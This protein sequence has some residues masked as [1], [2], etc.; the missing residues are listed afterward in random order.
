MFYI[1]MK[2]KTIKDKKIKYAAPEKKKAVKKN[3]PVFLDKS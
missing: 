3:P 1:Q 2:D